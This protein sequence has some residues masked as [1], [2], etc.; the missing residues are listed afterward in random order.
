MDP[1]PDEELDALRRRLYAPGVTAQDVA[2]YEAAAGVPEAAPAPAS[3]PA[4]PRRPRRAALI[5]VAVLAAAVLVG[6]TLAVARTTEHRA[7]PSASPTATIPEVIDARVPLAASMRTA[8]VARLRAGRSAGMLDLVEADPGLR[9]PQL[10]TVGRAASTEYSGTGPTVLRLD[11]S[12]LAERGG[13]ATVIVVLA[14]TGGYTW[15]AD[16]GERL[17]AAHASAAQAGAPV[18][19]TFAYGPGAPDRLLLLVPDRARWGAV[20]VFTD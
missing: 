11:P 3:P 5:G 8:L 10:T 2:R 17:I 1:R 12:A 4:A 6:A 16:R 13:R 20:V 19:S 18:A 9:P 15:R 14:G 7:T